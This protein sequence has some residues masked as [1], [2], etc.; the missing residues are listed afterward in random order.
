MVANASAQT[1]TR[2]TNSSGG[3]WTDSGNWDNGVPDNTAAAIFNR[4]AAS[5]YTVDVQA[6]GAAGELRAR[7]GTID[8]DLHGNTLA[9]DDVLFVGY[10]AGDDAYVKV[11]GGTLTSNWADVGHYEG[12]TMSGAPGRLDLTGDGTT[13]NNAMDAT[14]G[15]GTTGRVDVLTGADVVMGRNVYVG[16]AGSGEPAPAEGTLNVTG[17]GSSFTAGRVGAGYAGPGGAASQGGIV[18][19]DQATLS[20]TASQLQLGMGG[21]GSLV[22]TGY[23]QISSAK[24]TSPSG[25][26][27]LLGFDQGGGFYGQ[28]Y[29]AIMNRANWTQDGSLVVG[30]SARGELSIEDGATADSYAAHIGRRSGSVGIAEVTDPDST[31][32]VTGEMYVGGEAPPDRGGLGAGG[33]GSLTVRSGG[34]VT[35]GTRLELWPQGAVS[36]SSG[37]VFVGDDLPAPYP[38]GLYGVYVTSGGILCGDGTIGG[39]VVNQG[40]TI[41]PGHSAGTLT[42]DQFEQQTG[43]LELEIGGTDPGDYDCLVVT[44]DVLLDGQLKLLFDYL[45]KAGDTFDL[46][47]FGQSFAGNYQVGIMGLGSGWD[48][49]L[50]TYDGVL[51][52]TSNNDAL[53]IPEPSTLAIWSLGLVGLAAYARR[54]RTK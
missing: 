17:A 8:F 16:N 19:A 5:S 42:V 23:A 13:W 29:A 48:Y 52:L 12:A 44:D 31:W 25:T 10:S 32:A 41:A 2:W 15:R 39:R 50:S 3:S 49:D 43:I 46:V 45:P 9:V 20:C 26:S 7:T 30:F 24:G 28:G 33:Q 37:H 18:V 35:I 27:G 54:R 11:H 22:A 40:G 34:L 4:G 14:I 6:A 38:H 36:V 1:E 21:A 51:R 53:P 47:R